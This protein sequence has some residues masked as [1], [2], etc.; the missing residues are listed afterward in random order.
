MDTH[1]GFGGGVGGGG[2]LD[3]SVMVSDENTSVEEAVMNP[4]NGMVSIVPEAVALF[5]CPLT[6]TRGRRV[7]CVTKKPKYHS[8]LQSNGNSG[9]RYYMLKIDKKQKIVN[10]GDDLDVFYFE[11]ISI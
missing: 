8:S 11:L 3:A 6:L 4:D 2:G 10:F 7:D 9:L 5:N 1:D